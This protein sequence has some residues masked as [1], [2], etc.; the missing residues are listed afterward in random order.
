MGGDGCLTEQSTRLPKRRGA[1]ATPAGAPHTPQIAP[2]M[3]YCAYKNVTTEILVPGS[4]WY[5]RDRW[6]RRF[7]PQAPVLSDAVP[8]EEREPVLGCNCGGYARHPPKGVDRAFFWR[9]LGGVDGGEELCPWDKNDPNNTLRKCDSPRRY[10]DTIVAPRFPEQLVSKTLPLQLERWSKIKYVLHLD[11]QT[12]STRLAHYLGL[13]FSTFVEQSGYNQHFQEWMEPY[14]H[15]VPVWRDG[16]DD[17]PEKVEWARAHDREARLIG[18][19][20]REFALRHL[21]RESRDLYW[22]ALLREYGALMAYPVTRRS[23]A[24]PLREN[25]PKEFALWGEYG[26]GEHD[27]NAVAL[28]LYRRRRSKRRRR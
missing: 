8:W 24:V 19:R 3:R 13:G 20:A 25:I 10:Y 17:L 23:E 1:A 7:G 6:D 14:K 11:G 15:F 18:V 9:G 22:R 27:K 26:P 28:P 4:F 2:T 21:T 12:C 16:P 5:T